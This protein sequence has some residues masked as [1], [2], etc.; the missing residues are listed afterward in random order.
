MGLAGRPRFSAKSTSSRAPCWPLI[1]RRFRF[2]AISR[3]SKQESMTQSTFWS[4]EHLASLSQSPVSEADWLTGVVTWR[5][6]ILSW[7]N[8]SAPS[9]WFGRT[10]PASCH[11]QADGTL[12]PFSGAWS[13]SGMGSPT[14]CLTLSSS[15][16]HSAAAVC[17]LSDI[18]E[19]GD[20]PQRF[21]LS[22]TAC[23]GILRRA[24]KRGKELPPQLAHALRAAAGSERTSTST[25]D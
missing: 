7:L 24:G 17:S 21:F 18:L 16:Y 15:E 5:S 12:V 20:V 1:I 22:A 13:N 25:A 10:C 14:E 4:E 8:D 9:G 11:R 19:I 6:N 3:R 2:M 23:K